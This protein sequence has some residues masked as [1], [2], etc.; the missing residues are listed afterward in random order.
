MNSG[1]GTSMRLSPEETV[2][3]LQEELAET[4]REVLLLTLEL[5]SRVAELEEANRHL[6]RHRELIDLSSDAVI[7][8]DAHRTV[9]GWNTGAAEMYGWTEEE[10]LGRSINDLLDTRSAVPRE[11]IEAALRKR[12]RWS[13]ELNHTRRDGTRVIVESRQALLRDP[14]G[15]TVGILEINRDLTERQSL[16][17][18][19]RQSQKL[20]SIGQL[21]GGVAHDFNNLLTVIAG[22]A[23]MLLPDLAADNP[24]R[25]CLEE[26]ALAANRAAS[27]T[28]Q[29]LAFSRRQATEPVDLVLNDVVRSCEK[30][31]RRLITADIQLILSLEPGEGVVHADRGH[32][33]QVIMNLAINARDAMRAGG[34]LAIE[35]R[36]VSLD[37]ELAQSNPDTP[38]GEYLMLSVTDTGTGMPREIMARVFEPFFTTK[39]R[40]KGTGLGLSTV[41]G[42]VKQSRGSINVDSTPGLGTTFRILLP[43]S[44]TTGEEVQTAAAERNLS[45]NETILLAE[46]D[47]GVR[48]YVRQI[49]ERNGYRVLEVSN[50]QD[51][52]TLAGQ[53]HG[54]IHLLLTDV[55]MPELGGLEL[56]EQFAK[57]RPAASV[58][59]MSGYSDRLWQGKERA[60]HFLQKPFG[61]ATM[62]KEIRSLLDNSAAGP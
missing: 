53:H 60:A 47:A 38:P 20:E 10:A 61:A 29:L 59:C 16:E 33:E 54:P 27:L 26:I 4:N 41:Y 35:T 62:L 58:L 24:M 21:A 14:Q 19:L 39:E 30:M 25:E 50:G 37:G 55:V 51:A 52:V 44:T 28:R 56:A 9:T 8:M 48:R 6:R 13:G 40:G 18:Q 34:K 7:T 49:L 57:L 12:L 31:L 11:K 2:R 1:K 36:R 23:E 42:I 43:L 46:D 32:L 15:N 22:Y 3:L 45:G 17:E 5:E